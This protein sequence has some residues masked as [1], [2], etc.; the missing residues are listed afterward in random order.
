MVDVDCAPGKVIAQLGAE[1][2]HVTGQNHQVH[3][4]LLDHAP[5]LG[6]EIG[7]GLWNDHPVR[8]RHTVEIGQ[9]PQDFVIGH[10]TDNVD[11]Q[12][13]RAPPEQEF[14]EAVPCLRGQQQGAGRALRAV[15][16]EL[17]AEP[18]RHG[19]Q[20]A[21]Q[22]IACGPDQGDTGEE[23]SRVGG[24]ELLAFGYVATQ[25]D[26]NSGEGVHDARTVRAPQ[27]HDEVLHE[28][29]RRPCTPRI[30]LSTVEETL[31]WRREHRVWQAFGPWNPARLRNG[32]AAV[33]HPRGP[34]QAPRPPGRG[35]GR[36][37]SPPGIALPTTTGAGLPG[38][39]ARNGT[40]GPENP[41]GAKSR[42][43]AQQD[44]DQLLNRTS[45]NCSTEPRPMVQ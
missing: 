9:R 14:V 29:Q 34:L 11:G 6:L 26:D 18:L 8:E 38:A 24:G 21:H 17:R 10:D 36:R 44:P 39:R 32:P 40:P 15:D 25:G 3:L 5:D 2:L 35:S 22:L 37:T 12:G 1:D 45:A 42:P 7:L 13:S 43:I 31:T 33:I 30:P 28:P 4:P 16:V 19:T 20:S 27:R 41:R 23:P